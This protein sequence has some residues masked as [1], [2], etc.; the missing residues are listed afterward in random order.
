MEI[1]DLRETKSTF[2]ELYAGDVFE[3]I[4]VIYIKADSDNGASI[5][6]KDG[7]ITYFKNDAHVK[8]LENVKLV[9]GD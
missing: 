3:F 4:G 5:N 8:I 2:Y 1:K 9:I 6:L 7:E